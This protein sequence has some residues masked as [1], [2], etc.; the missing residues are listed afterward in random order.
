MLEAF[1]RG[2]AF[3]SLGFSPELS[4]IVEVNL[5]GHKFYCLSHL[6]LADSISFF[7]YCLNLR[8]KDGDFLKQESHDIIDTLGTTDYHP[9]YELSSSIVY[10]GMR[11]CK[12]LQP[13]KVHYNQVPL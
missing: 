7:F 11:T 13:S 4:G 6:L 3:F 9:M 5:A 8:K 12:F 10:L 1:A 2:S